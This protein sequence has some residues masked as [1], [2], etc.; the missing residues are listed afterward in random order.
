MGGMSAVENNL[1]GTPAATALEHRRQEV[2]F[3]F[4]LDRPDFVDSAVPRIQEIFLKLIAGKPADES[5]QTYLHYLA[6]CCVF[7]VNAVQKAAIG[8]CMPPVYKS[9][10]VLL[11]KKILLHALSQPELYYQF[12]ESSS[13]AASEND[14]DILPLGYDKN[15]LP[16]WENNTGLVIDKSLINPVTY[17][18][19]CR[20]MDDLHGRISDLQSRQALPSIDR[21]HAT[22][23]DEDYLWNMV[24]LAKLYGFFESDM[25]KAEYWRLLITPL[26]KDH[27]PEVIKQLKLDTTTLRSSQLEKLTEVWDSC[28]ITYWKASGTVKNA[29]SSQPLT[30]ADARRAAQRLPT[31]AQI[32]SKQAIVSNELHCAL[33][34]SR[35]FPSTLAHQQRSKSS[36]IYFHSNSVSKSWTSLRAHWL[37]RIPKRSPQTTSPQLSTKLTHCFLKMQVTKQLKK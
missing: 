19:V 5:K 13:N 18:S 23:L 26:I 2:P 29:G 3:T 12:F 31:T 4:Y 37:M 14:A 32:L 17:G 24:F 20:F 8:A 30:A 15:T 34:F 27:H 36:R 22:Q 25:P 33:K 16:I 9:T 11:Q 35:S 21:L 10:D 1:E 28:F 7:H 6:I